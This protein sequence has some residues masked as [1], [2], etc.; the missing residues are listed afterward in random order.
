VAAADMIDL[1]H[2]MEAYK[3]VLAGAKNR[4]VLKP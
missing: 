1:P 2:A 3:A 4:M